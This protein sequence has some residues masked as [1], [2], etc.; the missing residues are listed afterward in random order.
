MAGKRS[1]S[2]TICTPLRSAISCACPKSPNPV[3]SVTAFGDSGRS[4]SAAPLFS[5]RI[6]RTAR[7]SCCVP[8]QAL[9]VAA[10]DQ[11]GP[12]RLRHEHRIAGL[13]TVLRPDP[14]GMN[15]ADHRQSVLWLLIADRVPA[16]EQSARRAHLLVGGGEDRGQHLHGQ[17]LRER[18]DREREQRRPAHREHV[19][20]RIGRGDRAVVGRVVDDGREEV[21]RE[22]E[23]ALVVEPVDRG[24]VGRREPDEQVLGLDGHEPLQQLLEPRGGVLGCAAAA[25]RKVGKTDFSGLDIHGFAGMYPWPRGTFQRIGFP[26]HSHRRRRRP[27]KEPPALSGRGRDYPPTIRLPSRLPCGEAAPISSCNRGFLP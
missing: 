21:E 19:V 17:L 3:T 8:G 18:R 16:R 13:R 10:H 27:T 6:Q 4:T 24:V 20:Q 14:V 25:G 15:R 7:V 1:D 26:Q 12:E 2:R 22:D 23:R 9:L 11:P 5:V